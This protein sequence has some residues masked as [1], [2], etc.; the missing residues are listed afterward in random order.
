MDVIGF[1]YVSLVSC[2]DP[3]YD[4]LGS[5]R[6]CACSEAGFSS[7][8]G[9]GAWGVYYRRAAFCC[10]FMWTKGLNAKD[11]HKEIFS[12]YGG[13]CLSRKAVHS[14]VANVSL[15]RGWNGEVR[16]WLRQLLRVSTYW[17]SDGTRVSML[18]EDMSRNITRFIS[19]CD[20]F[21]DSS[22]YVWK[23]IDF[24]SQLPVDAICGVMACSLV[25][26]YK[27]FHLHLQDMRA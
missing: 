1:L 2:T 13:K 12:V 26:R 23:F 24:Y 5:R 10:D 8:N 21:T 6:A 11:V 15:I 4:N 20:V 16:K 18:V 17:W 22:S 19:T 27:C 7:E 9:N 14:W 25:V 3:L